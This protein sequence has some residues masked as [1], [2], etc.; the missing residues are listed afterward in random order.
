M[1]DDF[2][3]QQSEVVLR[4]RVHSSLSFRNDSTTASRRSVSRDTNPRLTR[5][6]ADRAVAVLLG[7]SA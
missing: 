7:W 6:P 3:G 4:H 1:V 5:S 2:G